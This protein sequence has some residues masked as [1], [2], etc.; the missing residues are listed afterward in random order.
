MGFEYD[1]KLFNEM[2][3]DYIE[4]MISLGVSEETLNIVTQLNKEGKPV[5]NESYLHSF[6]CFVNDG[7]ARYSSGLFPYSG[8][9]GTGW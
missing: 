7:A 3:R 1:K 2:Q 8:H 4:L 5:F 9:P 6:Y